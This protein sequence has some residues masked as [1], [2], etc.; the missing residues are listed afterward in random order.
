MS[1][2]AV[3]TAMVTS[4]TTEKHINKRLQSR[5]MQKG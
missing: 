4:L 3:D 2:T 5:H 1:V